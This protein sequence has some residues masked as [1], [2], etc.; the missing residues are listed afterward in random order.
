MARHVAAGFDGYYINLMI[1]LLTFTATTL[2]IVPLFVYV[3]LAVQTH[4]RRPGRPD[5]LNPLSCSI[6]FSD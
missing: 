5:Q 4:Q 6:R 2:I 1:I 3:A